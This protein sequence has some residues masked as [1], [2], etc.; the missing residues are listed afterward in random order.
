MIHFYL[1]LPILY[2]R[3]GSLSSTCFHLS[4]CYPILDSLS[5]PCTYSIA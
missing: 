2:H 5:L 4:R 1:S 3:F